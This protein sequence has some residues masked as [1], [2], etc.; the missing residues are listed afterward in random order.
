VGHELR[1]QSLLRRETIRHVESS[2]GEQVCF[3]WNFSGMEMHL[4][5]VKEPSSGA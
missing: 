5:S 2:F 1:W 3:W 4:L